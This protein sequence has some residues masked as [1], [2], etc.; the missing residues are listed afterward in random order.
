MPN[1][2]EF[3]E[4]IYTTMLYTNGV[5]IL[6]VYGRRVQGYA[7]GIVRVKTG[8]LKADIDTRFMSQAGLPVVQ[9]G[10]DAHYGEY[11]HTGTGI[12]G[13]RRQRIYPKKGKY[14]VFRGRDGTLV[15]AT[16]VRGMRPNQYLTRAMRK[17]FGANIATRE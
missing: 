13:P 10:V 5:T 12:Y 16:S 8:W 9:V 17:V 15:F 3:H 4:N 6:M 1:R 14:L 7:R 11:V 2:I